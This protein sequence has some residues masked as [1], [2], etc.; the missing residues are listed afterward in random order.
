M[1]GSAWCLHDDLARAPDLPIIAINAAS[2]EVRAFALYSCHPERFKARP[3]RWI[4]RQRRRFGDGFTV[5]GGR[6]REG[7]PWVQHWWGPSKGGGSAWGARKMAFAMGFTEVILCGCPL[8][9][10][11]YTGHKP[12]A[13]MTRQNVIEDLRAGVAADTDWHKA[14]YSMSGWTRDLLGEPPC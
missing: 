14:C 5:H 2:D 7:M 9:S 11:N 4:D 10:G 8:D 3:W 6:F 13:L 1:A 12:G